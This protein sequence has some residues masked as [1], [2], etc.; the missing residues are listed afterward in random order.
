MEGDLERIHKKKIANFKLLS[1]FRNLNIYN[2]ERNM[3][4]ICGQPS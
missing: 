2:N 3:Q 4:E 1:H